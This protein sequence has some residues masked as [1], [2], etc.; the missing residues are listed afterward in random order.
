MEAELNEVKNPSD[1]I[2]NGAKKQLMEN[3]FKYGWNHPQ[4]NRLKAKQPVLT[5]GNFNQYL[6]YRPR[7]YHFQGRF[8]LRPNPSMTYS[9]RYVS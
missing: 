7:V 1:F 2:L 5:L 6:E 8:I 4:F 9:D 3:D